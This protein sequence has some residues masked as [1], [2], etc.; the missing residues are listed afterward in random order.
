MQPSLRQEPRGTFGTIQ[1]LVGRAFGILCGTALRSG[2]RRCSQLSESLFVCDLLLFSLISGVKRFGI[3]A[4]GTRPELCTVCIT[5]VGQ[6]RLGHGN[7]A[8]IKIIVELFLPPFDEADKVNKACVLGPSG[9]RGGGAGVW[10]AVVSGC[11]I[12]SARLVRIS[13]GGSFASSADDADGVLLTERIGKLHG[14]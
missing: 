7:A 4:A 8:E 14:T 2:R 3:R 12:G 13:C 6:V 5:L 11:T 10:D 1:Q 9:G